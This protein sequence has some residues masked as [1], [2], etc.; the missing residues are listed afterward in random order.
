LLHPVAIHEIA[1][2]LHL[3]KRHTIQLHIKK[4]KHQE[5]SSLADMNEEPSSE[6]HQIWYNVYQH[7]PKLA[8]M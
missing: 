7:H 8:S 4:K 3:K 6:G 5:T 1:I 2:L